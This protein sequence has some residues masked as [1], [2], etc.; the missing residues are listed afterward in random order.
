[1]CN[2]ITFLKNIFLQMF[3]TLIFSLI[4]FEEFHL[5]LYQQI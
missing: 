2:I 4:F 5:I 1:M 3:M